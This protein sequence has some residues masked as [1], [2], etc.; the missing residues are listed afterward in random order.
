MMF[1]ITKTADGVI[2]YPLHKHEFWEIMFYIEGDGFLHTPA[3]DYKF[4]KGTAILVPPEVLHGSVSKSG[5]KNISIGGNFERFF[6]FNSPLT[7]NDNTNCDGRYLANMI[8][9]NR[10]GSKAYI[11]S[12]VNAYIYFLLDQTAFSNGIDIAVHNVHT[13]IKEN[14]QNPDININRILLSSGYA[15]DYIRMHFSKRYGMPPVKFLTKVRIDCACNLIQIY[16]HSV[17]LTEIAEK[18]GYTDYIYFS[19]QFKSITG[20]SPREYLNASQN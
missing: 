8:F 4:T 5:F 6:A 14:A 18:S 9:Q 10:Y 13:K 20:K 16:R 2:K 1:S 11:E 19:K 15:E 3:A 7:V 17:S 12:L